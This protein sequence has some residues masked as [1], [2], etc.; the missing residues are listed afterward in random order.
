MGEGFV[1]PPN[2]H[3][4]D[5]DNE[6]IPPGCVIISI[7]W[8]AKDFE[9][10]ELDYENPYGIKVLGRCICFDVPWNKEDIELE[11]PTP[12]SL[13]SADASSPP[14]DDGGSN[15][16]D[17]GGDD[18][19]TPPPS[20][21]KATEGTEASQG[22]KAPIG[23][24]QGTRHEEVSSPSKAAASPE[25]APGENSTP[26]YTKGLQPLTPCGTSASGCKTQP[27]QQIQAQECPPSPKKPDDDEAIPDTLPYSTSFE[28]YA[29]NDEL[30]PY[31]TNDE[32][33]F[34]F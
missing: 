3:F 18:N 22:D 28:R 14:V 26:P 10:H 17:A 4:N 15:D 12:V 30:L 13:A 21:T 8:V 33:R 11:M 5:Y 32:L 20:P 9:E 24:Q 1:Y 34:T 7:A 27:P 6:D 2:H 29:T 19:R 16:N 23:S 31:I 25:E